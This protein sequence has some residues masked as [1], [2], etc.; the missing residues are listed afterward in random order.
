MKNTIKLFA[1]ILFYIVPLV[2]MAQTQTRDNAGLQGDAGAVSGFFETINPVNYPAGASSWWH[3]LDVRHSNSVNNFAMQFAGSFFDQNLYF[4][5]T[6]NNAGQPWQKVVMENDGKVGIGRVPQYN[7]DVGGTSRTDGQAWFSYGNA[8]IGGYSWTNA[9]LTTN[10]IEIVN[11]Q[12]T[13]TNL[14]P[15]LVFHRHGS[16]GPQFRLAADGSNILYLESAG[17]NSS[18][19]PLAYGGGPNSYFSKL[20]IDADLTAMGNVGIGTA[21]PREKLSV[22]GN[23]RARE[24]KVE[25][26]NWP[27]Y[28]FEEGY[29]IG[30]LKGLESYIKTNK[31]LPEMPS[32]AGVETNGLAVSEMFKL[33]QK[34]I[35]ELTLHLIEKDKQLTAQDGEVTKLKAKLIQQDK[36]LKEILKKL[37]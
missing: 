14:S 13:V 9:A 4:R 21:T 11:N 5:K 18:R 26:T 22:N 27:D 10:S 17:A 36:I 15:T 6:S 7:F 20:Y 28:V 33:Q 30:T 29:N 16:G 1:L 19:S 32:A 24:V 23:I 34:K 12:G 25:A 37:K 35:E 8:S 3:L 31:R 2:T